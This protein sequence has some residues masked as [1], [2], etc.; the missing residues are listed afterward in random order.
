ML[1]S[2][3]FA[4]GCVVAL[5]GIS[6]A[7]AT[8]PIGSLAWTI[9]AAVL[10]DGPG[11]AYDTSGQVDGAVHVRVTRCQKLWCHVNASTG[12][13][14]VSKDDLSFGTVPY[15]PFSGPRLAYPAG[16]PGK[17]CFYEGANYTGRSLCGGSGF[18][19]R[20]LKLTAFENR[21]SSVSVEGNVSATLCRDRFFQS[22]CQRIIKSQPH[23]NGFLAN[24]ASSLHVY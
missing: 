17:V 10:M 22:Y 16:G 2:L 23:L 13:G 14:W 20:D 3:S 9:R 5:L 7:E 12:S 8:P 6:A 18:V 4:L 24:A 11:T 1:K 19:V 21:F 15:G